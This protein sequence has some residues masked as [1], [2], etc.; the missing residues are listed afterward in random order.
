M[1]PMMVRSCFRQ[2]N[3]ISRS[4][5][6]TTIGSFILPWGVRFERP[7]MM[8]SFTPLFRET[9][10]SKYARS[11]SLKSEPLGALKLY[12]DGFMCMRSHV[13]SKSSKSRSYEIHAKEQG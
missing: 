9:N 2:K 12:V 1:T 13:S 3:W 7:S 6:P 10:A 4:H 8:S 11:G 5:E